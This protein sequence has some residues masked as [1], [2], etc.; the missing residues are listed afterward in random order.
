M[1]DKVGN[2]LNVSDLRESLLHREAEI[3]LLQQT[4]TD[5]GSELDLDR[6]FQ[7]VAERARELVKAETLLI[8][9]LDENCETY[10]YRA[11][12]GINIDEI[13][14]ESLPLDYGVCGWVWKHKKAWWRGML[15]EL[16][17]AERN[18]WEKEAGTLILVPLQ[19]KK[20]FL[21]G[22][23]AINKTG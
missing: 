21:G 16:S 8:P 23:A 10:T 18:R 12:S 1:P 2:N 3:D 4:F 11:G 17:E 13:V 7:I 9:I 19:G 22:I 15:D 20:H 5:I 6:V 14:G